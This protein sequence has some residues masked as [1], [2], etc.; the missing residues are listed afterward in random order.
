MTDAFRSLTDDEVHQ[1]GL[2]IESLER[3]TFDFLQLEFGDVKLTVGKGQPPPIVAAA[4]QVA[5]AP[6]VAAPQTASTASTSPPD[7]SDVPPTAVAD[8][9]GRNKATGGDG[10]YIVAPLLGRFYARPEPG[11]PPF[12]SVGS[13]VTEDTTVGLIEVMKTFNAVRAGIG[14]VVTE[15]CVQDAE[16]VEYGEVLFHVRPS[17]TA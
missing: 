17:K 10:G 8:N 11:A 6:S 13:A 15:I 7:A 12:V 16:L 5:V 9:G 1:I 2:I 14:G 4:P 3:S